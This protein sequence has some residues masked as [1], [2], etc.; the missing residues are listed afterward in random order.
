MSKC[1]SLMTEEIKNNN[2]GQSLSNNS[3]KHTL[4]RIYLLPGVILTLPLFLLQSAGCWLEAGGGNG[5]RESSVFLG[6]C[7]DK[8]DSGGRVFALFFAR[9]STMLK[10]L[11]SSSSF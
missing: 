9:R 7:W 3:I 6:F 11:N 1:I 10:L 5:Y 8:Y 4:V 2:M